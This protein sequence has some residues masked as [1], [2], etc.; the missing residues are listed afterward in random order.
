MTNHYTIEIISSKTFLK[1]T[2]RDK[3]FRKL[4]HLRGKLDEAMMRQIGR[5]LPHLESEIGGFNA[6]HEGKVNYSVIVKDETIFTKFNSEWISFFSSM[7][8]HIEPKM[9]A[10][11]SKSL[12]QI[13]TYLKQVNAGDELKALEVWQLI[14]GSYDQ[15]DKFY[16]DNLDLKFI[17]SKLNVII[18]KI[19]SSNNISTASGGGTVGL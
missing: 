8:P 17:N 15:L 12:S 6:Q 4:E 7:P 14:L 5:I 2:Y 13:I 10:A 1:I 16:K 9:T 11:D 3:K 18:R 19:Q